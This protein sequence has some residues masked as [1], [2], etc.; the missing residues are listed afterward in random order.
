MNLF[1]EE[2]H[3]HHQQK[4]YKGPDV[5]S[6]D[7]EKIQVS[8]ENEMAERKVKETSAS[9]DNTVVSYKKPSIALP[10]NQFDNVIKLIHSME[11]DQVLI[12]RNA[13]YTT[14]RRLKIKRDLSMAINRMPSGSSQVDFGTIITWLNK[15]YLDDNSAVNQLLAID[16]TCC[17]RT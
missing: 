4:R 7:G 16:A 3:K 11:R 17:S 9:L 5:L 1:V 10:K 6:V 12:I 2:W 14:L 15:I 13:T 8:G